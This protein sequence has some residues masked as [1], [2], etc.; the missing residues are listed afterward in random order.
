M[1]RAKP[2]SCPTEPHPSG[3]GVRWACLCAGALMLSFAA[4]LL[5]AESDGQG[6][7]NRAGSSSVQVFTSGTERV[8][9]IELYS[10]Q[11]C[12]SCPAAE[13]W[14]GEW[15]D[16][17]ELWTRRVPLNFHV[18]YWD[19]L[20]WPDPYASAD[21][22]ERQQRYARLLG[23]PAPYTP[24]FIL[25][26]RE[27]RGFFSRAPLPDPPVGMPGVLRA[28]RTASELAFDYVPRADTRDES[29]P[30]ASELV[31]HAALLGI[32]LCDRIPAG[33]NRGRQLRQDFVVLAQSS[34]RARRDSDGF[35]GE[36][37]LP[38]SRGFEPLRF[39]LA[40]WVTER[41]GLRPLQATGG[42][43]NGV[44]GGESRLRESDSSR[45]SC[46]EA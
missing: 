40:L 32:G 37:R 35:H 17:D 8:Q 6:D 3:A 36:L 12:S 13:S 23:M 16:S 24:G 9:L 7:G 2:E 44:T 26:G 39:A 21:H 46:P 27:W 45:V 11:G 34:V 38:D 22:T 43:L 18:D 33:E 20:G 15:V 41:G 1:S 42:W 30:D 19:R 28:T 29:A 25:D 31:F 10:S 5:R 14:L 4:G